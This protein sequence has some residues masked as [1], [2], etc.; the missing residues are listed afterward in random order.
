MTPFPLD[1]L[2]VPAAAIF[3]VTLLVSLRVTRS[4]AIAI[5]LGFIKAGVFCWYFGTVFDGT[6][7]FIDDWTYFER[8]VLLLREDVR[9]SNLVDNW[10][11]VLMLGGGDHFVYY[12]YNTYA[13]RLFGAYYFAPVALNILLTVPIAYLG[14]RLAHKELNLSARTSAGLYVFL[15]LHP[16]IL[17]WSSLINGKDVLVLLLHIVLLYAVAL[18]LRGR[19]RRALFVGLPAVLILFFLRFYV[20]LLFAIALIASVM[21]RRRL[22]WRMIGYVFLSLMLVAGFA[23]WIGTSTFS[24]AADL[25]RQ[26]FVNPAFGFIR[27]ALTPVPFNT[28]DAFSFLNIPAALHWMLFPFFLAGAHRV[29]RMHTP[30]SKFFMAYVA[31]FMGLYAVFGEL[32]GPRHRV[33]LDFAWAVFQY[34]GVLGFLRWMQRPD[35]LAPLLAARR[36]EALK[37]KQ[38]VQQ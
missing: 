32:Q 24:Y 22:T 20:P 12:L 14:A 36:Q 34:I 15:L 31:V 9:I 37:N 4:A 10:Q 27:M 35:A 18:Y 26:H 21:I 8:G 11:L 7:T 6:Y 33:Q 2:V 1:V 17:T 38:W 19:L 28:E 3:L 29:W 13:F 23:L 16:D 25:M 5:S 30:F